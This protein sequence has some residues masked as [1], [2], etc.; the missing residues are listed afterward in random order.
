MGITLRWLINESKLVNL[1]C[2][3]CSDKLDTPIESVNILDNPDVVKWIK[4]NELALT[5]GYLIKDNTERQRKIIHDLYDVG[6][7]ALCIKIKRF[8]K[9]I[10]DV[11]IDEAEKV[12]LPLIEIPFFY[13][14]SDLSKTIYHGIYTMETMTV[15]REQK[16]TA[17]LSL[18]FFNK[19]AVLEMLYTISD[20]LGKSVLL[21]DS[22]L[23]SREIAMTKEQ[24]GLYVKGDTFKTDSRI[25][26]INDCEYNILSSGNKVNT[27]Y[28]VKLPDEGG[29]L[30]I[31]DET[32]KF[33]EHHRAILQNAAVIVGMALEKSKN[34]KV[35]STSKPISNSEQFMAFLTN[36]NGVSKEQIIYLC[37]IA[38]FDYK[39]KRICITLSLKNIKSDNKK[40]EIIDLINNYINQENKAGITDNLII[41]SCSSNNSVCIFLLTDATIENPD[42]RK[43]ACD[44]TEELKN[45][46]EKST[47]LNIPAGIS[48]CHIHIDQ[49]RSAY[50]EAQ[51]ALL[52]NQNLGRNDK[53]ASYS[54]QIYYHLL[55]KC[56][57]EELKNLYMNNA[58]YLERYDKENNT[59]LLSTLKAY[60]MNCFNASE[61]AKKLF[62]HRN[63]LS[64][65]LDKIKDILN[66]S[67]NDMEE[68]FA[69]YLEMCAAD[70][71][72]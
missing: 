63:T 34:A 39:K 17:D 13:S 6:C 18:L 10:P 64:H 25:R 38:G 41:Y 24:S 43:A 2:V 19:G 44:F 33:S 1:R 32:Y 23:I 65:R 50:M 36:I 61:T 45:I 35:S 20:F 62:I 16:L 15:Q 66:I 54:K 47:K 70:L 51:D 30:C 68:L 8:F 40:K 49:I 26:N 59:E 9:S 3:A 72:E 46:I 14:F 42:L 27:F 48:K 37:D 60:L 7:S 4:H 58:E 12:G 53:F 67:L 55:S 52:L 71:L 56:T 69:I 11:M 5:T 22:N 31:L 21:L 57:Q 29:F 28:I